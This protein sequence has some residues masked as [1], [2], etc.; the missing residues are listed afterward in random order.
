M[1]PAVAMATTVR[2]QAQGVLQVCFWL[3]ARIRTTTYCRWKRK[4]P[5][6]WCRMRIHGTDM[7]VWSLALQSTV[8]SHSLCRL[9]NSGKPGFGVYIGP[10]TKGGLSCFWLQLQSTLTAMQSL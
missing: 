9:P 7:E 6:L 2:G 10:F 3:K 4:T 5:A 8:E 1:L